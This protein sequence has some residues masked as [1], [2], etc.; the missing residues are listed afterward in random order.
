MGS[1]VRQG[2]RGLSLWTRK[3]SRETMRKNDMEE[4]AEVH[5]EDNM[6]RDL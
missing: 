5:V 4:P 6:W 1:I 2:M 3:W